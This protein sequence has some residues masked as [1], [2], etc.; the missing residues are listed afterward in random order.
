MEALSTL[1]FYKSES[2]PP[3]IL[4]ADKDIDTQKGILKD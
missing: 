1:Y 3:R 2:T 4:N